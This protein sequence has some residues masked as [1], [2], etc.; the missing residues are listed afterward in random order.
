[1]PSL[2]EEVLPRPSLRVRR[3]S[4]GRDDAKENADERKRHLEQ[5]F[6]EPTEVLWEDLFATVRQLTVPVP[7]KET[8]TQTN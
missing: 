2:G 3:A 4:S 5:H 7:P 1:V 8:Q 6:T